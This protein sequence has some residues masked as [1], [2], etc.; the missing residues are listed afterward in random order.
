M[1]D[2]SQEAYLAHLAGDIMF[3]ERYLDLLENIYSEHDTIMEFEASPRHFLNRHGI[4]VPDGIDV[5]IHDPGALGRPARVD[6][7]W[8]EEVEAA[9][10]E[11]VAARQ[12]L[13]E[14]AR[15]AWETLHNPEMMQLRQ[16]VQASPGALKEFAANPKTYAADHKVSIPEQ[17]DVIVHLD[18][19]N[20]LKID[21]HFSA[22]GRVSRL[23][24]H[25]LGGGCCYCSGG[26]CCYYYRN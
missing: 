1:S 10:T 11:M 24:V 19:P 18:N 6:F 3:G 5:I 20:D 17:M 22:P 25:P 8:G 26:G 21:L 4:H 23:G 9:R 12:K 13:R 16:V 2:N 14:L 15:L 7:H